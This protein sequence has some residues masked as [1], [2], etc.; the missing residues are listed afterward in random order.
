MG[1]FQ[2]A[3]QFHYYVNVIHQ[4]ED[5][6]YRRPSVV[7]YDFCA[8]MALLCIKLRETRRLLHKWANTEM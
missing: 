1:T 6:I 7:L 4:K 3:M 2:M 5:T 8:R